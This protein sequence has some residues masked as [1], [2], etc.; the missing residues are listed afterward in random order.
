[1]ATNDDAGNSWIL[2]SGCTMHATPHMHLFSSLE[3][4]NAGGVMLGD[5]TTLQIKG[6]GKVP[7]RMHD[8]VV[9][10]VQ[11]V[12]WVPNLRRSLLS[13]SEFDNLGCHINTHNGIRE[14][15][16]D[17]KTVI[18]SIKKGGLY[19]VIL[20]PEI[21]TVDEQKALKDTHKWHTR[22][23]HIGNKGLLHLYTSGLIESQ[24]IHLKFCENYVLSKK[25]SHAFNKSTFKVNQ[26]LEYVHS[27]LWGPAQ[28]A[29]VGG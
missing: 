21:N 9:R 22:L 2:D 27:D 16:K 6:I 13:E 12:G 20:S 7:L 10:T 5:Q 11:N 4:Q 1:M 19:H 29:T 18:K 8:G 28:V 26:P 23:G 3:L 15:I 14:V 24:P 25:T 17:N